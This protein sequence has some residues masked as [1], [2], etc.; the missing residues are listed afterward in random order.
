MSDA[1]VWGQGKLPRATATARPDCRVSRRS[2]A[3]PADCKLL[4]VPLS[5]ADY[6]AAAPVCAVREE[7]PAR[8]NFPAAAKPTRVQKDCSLRASLHNDVERLSNVLQAV[9]FAARKAKGE[10]LLN[11]N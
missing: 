6:D 7:E 1:A 5:P 10:L 11:R 9:D 8:E 4:L 2:P 3:L